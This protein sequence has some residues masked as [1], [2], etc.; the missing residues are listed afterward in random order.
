MPAGDEPLRITLDDLADETPTAAM[1]RTAPQAAPPQPPTAPTAPAPPAA[2]TTPMTAGQALPTITPGPAPVTVPVG[3]TRGGPP[4]GSGLS[5][6]GATPIV[7][8]LA[9][10]LIAGTVGAALGWWLNHSVI[11]RPLIENGVLAVTVSPIVGFLLAA[12]PDLTA[13][14]VR[15][16]LR[17]GAIGAIAGLV[18]A[19]AAVAVADRIFDDVRM[20][21]SGDLTSD[22]E[23]LKLAL[24]LGWVILGTLVGFGLGI[25]SGLRKV[26]NGAIGGFVGGVIGGFIYVQTIDERT[27]RIAEDADGFA[28]RFGPQLISILATTVSVC[29]AIGIAERVARQAWLRVTRGPL[30]GKEY[31]LYRDS[32][33][34]GSAGTCDVVLAKDATVAPRHA[35]IERRNGTARVRS[36]GAQ[37]VFVNGAP[38]RDAPLRS[39]DVIGVASFELTYEER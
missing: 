36:E 5:R 12:W 38:V 18:A 31:I 11:D 19:I 39:G 1:A 27:L 20:D 2:P 33:V 35:S 7:S 13:G 3:D 32:T 24:W 22:V 6:F 34:I 37:P 23:K 30:A 28:S 25:T 29:L 26:V 4:G 9:V 16:G 21:S 17:R 8:G 10:G 15:S 14:A